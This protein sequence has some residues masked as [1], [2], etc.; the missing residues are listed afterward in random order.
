MRERPILYV[1]SGCPWCQEAQTFFDQ[2]GVDVDIVDVNR[3][4]SAMN[5]MVEVSGQ[6]KTPT[7]EC[8]DF[9]VADFDTDEFMAEL[10]EFPEIRRRL[11]IGD[12]E[13]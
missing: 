13:T 11:G 12:D 7:F 8:G 6:T 3:D 2:H 1:K 10:D 5:R 9:V 4:R